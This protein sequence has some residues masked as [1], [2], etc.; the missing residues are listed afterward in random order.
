MEFILKYWAFIL[1]FLSAFSGI[2]VMKV[3]ILHLKKRVAKNED[4]HKETTKDLLRKM[5][6]TYEKM[7]SIAVGVAE[8]KGE[9]KGR[10]A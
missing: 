3:E 7:E 2:A 8:I 10:S 4:E 6:Q 1:A 9:L 5:E